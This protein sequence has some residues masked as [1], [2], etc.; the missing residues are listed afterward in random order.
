[1]TWYQL[2]NLYDVELALYDVEQALKDA[3]KALNIQEHA[4]NDVEWALFELVL[5]DVAYRIVPKNRT[6]Y[7]LNQN[8]PLA[9]YIALS[10]KSE[11]PMLGCFNY[12]L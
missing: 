11:T 8:F 3:E 10:L 2:H 1:M 9:I 5:N 12:L 7:S 4:L 6:L